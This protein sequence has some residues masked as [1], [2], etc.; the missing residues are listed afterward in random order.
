MKTNSIRIRQASAADVDLVAPL[1]DAYRQ[2]YRQRSDIECARRFLF[3][4]LN[5]GQSVILLAFDESGVVGFTQLYPSFSSAAMARIFILN[6]LF[7][8]PEAR[9]RG[10]GSAL[11]RAAADYGKSAGAIR[12]M[13]STE[14]TNTTAQSVYESNGWERD[15]VFCVYRLAL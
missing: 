11:L 6:D 2:F 14:L 13:L 12:L 9:G 5:N 4:R 15:A 8:A 1:F 7:V 3:D 10:A